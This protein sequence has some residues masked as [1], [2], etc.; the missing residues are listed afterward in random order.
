MPPRR[1]VLVLTKSDLTKL[2]HFMYRMQAQ[3]NLRARLRGNAVLLAH[4]HRSVPEIAQALG[5][6]NRTIYRW[7]KGYRQK[8]ID[9][10]TEPMRHRKLSPAQVQE[11]MEISHFRDALSNPKIWSSVWTYRKM[12]D[13]IK[14]NWQIV[15]SPERVRQI[16]KQFLRGNYY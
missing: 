14:E 9:G 15:L 12:A 5:K 10:L 6:D 1:S 8:G 11:L 4:Q 13:W 3:G 16:I 7:L 2:Q